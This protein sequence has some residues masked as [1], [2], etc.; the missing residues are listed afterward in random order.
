LSIRDFLT[1]KLILA[2]AAGFGLVYLLLADHQS[3]SHPGWILMGVATAALLVVFRLPALL[4]RRTEMAKLLD[5][6]DRSLAMEDDEWAE[7]LLRSARRMV[8]TGV[9]EMHL[10]LDLAEGTLAFRNGRYE[11]AL[12]ALERCFLNAFA[13]HD[14]KHGGESGVLLLKTLVA[15]GRYSE[16]C[17]FAL[18]VREMTASPELDHLVALAS[19]RAESS[20]ELAPVRARR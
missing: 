2:G 16:A 15:L 18:G 1:S 12:L 10:H 4:N 3:P 19:N 14:V 6:L 17:G 5:R 11:E 20:M 8:G 13:I 7:E 9:S